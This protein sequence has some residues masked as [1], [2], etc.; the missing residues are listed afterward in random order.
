M[1]ARRRFSG[2]GESAENPA[3]MRRIDKLFLKCPSVATA[4]A[5][6]TCLPALMVETAR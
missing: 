6:V 5:L 4:G 1:S 3:L 2:E